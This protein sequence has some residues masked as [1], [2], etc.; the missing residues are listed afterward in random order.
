MTCGSSKSQM[1]STTACGNL[2]RD[3]NHS[4]VSARISARSLNTRSL[5]RACAPGHTLFRGSVHQGIQKQ[6]ISHDVAHDHASHCPFIWKNSLQLVHHYSHFAVSAINIYI[7]SWHCTIVSIGNFM[8]KQ[9]NTIV[10][11]ENSTMIMNS[12]V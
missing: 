1:F 8:R 10:K 7:V 4:S 9:S 5:P 11:Q 6:Q 3:S 2:K 12:E